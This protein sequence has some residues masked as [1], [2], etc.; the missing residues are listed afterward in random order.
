MQRRRKIHEIYTAC[1]EKKYPGR[2]VF[3]FVPILQRTASRAHDHPHQA[4]TSAALKLLRRRRT[5]RKFG[6]PSRD[7]T[8]AA[9]VVIHAPAAATTDFAAAMAAAGISF[10]DVV[11]PWCTRFATSVGRREG[12]G[13]GGFRSLRV[14][15]AAVT[16][17]TT[18]ASFVPRTLVPFARRGILFGACPFAF[19]PFAVVSA[20]AVAAVRR[21][22][23]ATPAVERVTRVGRCSDAVPRTA[24]RALCGFD[25]RR[26]GAG[27]T[28][29]AGRTS[30]SSSASESLATRFAMGVLRG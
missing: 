29:R 16:S 30:P 26:T 19:T 2:P 1:N 6:R 3:R 15:G 7:T 18:L 23:A 11:A 17:L 22:A 28:P 5:G 21:A 8:A 20:V 10:T 25:F 13:D 4:T 27:A 12:M 14:V 24:G 9:F